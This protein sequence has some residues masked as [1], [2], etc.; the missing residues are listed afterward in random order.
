MR[1]RIRSVE[2]VNAVVLAAGG[3]LGWPGACGAAMWSPWVPNSQ[4]AAITAHCATGLVWVNVE[5]T[6]GDTCYR[7]GDWG[8]VVQT[9]PTI[10]ANSA[11]WYNPLGP[12]A[13]VVT[14][15]NHSYQLG[16]LAP[17]NYQFV[18]QSWG[19]PVATNNFTVPATDSDGDHMSDYDEWIAGTNP[20][21]SR[22]AL[23]VIG[24]KF[25]GGE[26]RIT[27]QGGTNAQQ[28]VERRTNLND[29][30]SGWQCVFT[31]HPPTSA[32]N[33]FV[34]SLSAEMPR[35]YRIRVQR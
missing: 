28:Y 17:G 12:C 22:S 10:T 8:S 2:L 13:Y 14:R 11:C 23:K 26:A 27:W 31:N 29:A 21:D 20:A 30:G 33:V 35:F 18:F 1:A 5:V 24:Y 32:T 34:D 16:Y 25:E 4:V 3:L 19:Q 15:T 7:V 6:L 9:L